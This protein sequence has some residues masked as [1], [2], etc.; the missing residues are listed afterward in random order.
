[1]DTFFITKIRFAHQMETEGQQLNP[2]SNTPATFQSVAGR[3]YTTEGNYSISVAVH[4]G[5]K[6]SALERRRRVP[7]GRLEMIA[8]VYTPKNLTHAALGW[9]RIC[10]CASAEAS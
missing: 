10:P 2:L 9:C 5:G 7:A 1:M 4:I 6:A 8:L 3:G